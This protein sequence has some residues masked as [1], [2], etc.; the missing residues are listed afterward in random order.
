MN[1]TDVKSKKEGIHLKTYCP[2]SKVKG[3]E[4]ACKECLGTDPVFMTSWFS[5]F[6]QD[7]YHPVPQLSHVVK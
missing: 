7:T 5:D 6:G 4:G 2:W 1:R 3:K